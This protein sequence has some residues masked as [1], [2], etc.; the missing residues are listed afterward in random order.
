VYSSIKKYK[1]TKRGF[2]SKVQ[3]W[4]CQ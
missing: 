3:G 1:G 2:G 4:K